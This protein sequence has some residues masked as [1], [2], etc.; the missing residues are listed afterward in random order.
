MTTFVISSRLFLR[1]APTARGRP[2]IPLEQVVVYALVILS[3]ASFV[4]GAAVAGPL[5]AAGALAEGLLGVVI[6]VIMFHR[7]LRSG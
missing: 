2:G 3:G 6:I 1:A 7:E 5:A 4:Y